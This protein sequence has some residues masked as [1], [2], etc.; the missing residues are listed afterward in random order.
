MRIMVAFIAGV[1]STLM[2]TVLA[3]MIGDTGAMRIEQIFP[4]TGI[5]DWSAASAS[6]WL[7][8][9][10]T[11]VTLPLSFA[12]SVV[13]RRR[14]PA[15]SFVAGAIVGVVLGAAVVWCCRAKKQ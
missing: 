8:A 7:G 1:C 14:W 3:V 11:A 6:I 13:S 12:L 15:R 9:L 2:L 10:V 5:E 4:E